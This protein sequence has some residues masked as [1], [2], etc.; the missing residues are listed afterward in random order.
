MRFHPILDKKCNLWKLRKHFFDHKGSDK[1]QAKGGIQ[2]AKR[3]ENIHKRK[4]GRWEG[5]YIK[6]RTTDGKPIWGYLYGYAYGKV[7]D[8]L[9]KRKVLSGFYQLSGKSMRFSA[10]AEL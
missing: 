9:M 2:M 3:G 7:K 8:E 6:G 5:R 10:L 1:G 4:D